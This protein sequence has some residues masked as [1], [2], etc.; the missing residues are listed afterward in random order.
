MT[1]NSGRIEF[2]RD[3]TIGWQYRIVTDDTVPWQV[4]PKK[5]ALS[6]NDIAAGRNIGEL[7][8]EDMFR[9]SRQ[10]YPDPGTLEGT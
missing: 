5:V 1:A 4:V 3:P 6:M 8:S 2:R 10:L 9:L 7:D